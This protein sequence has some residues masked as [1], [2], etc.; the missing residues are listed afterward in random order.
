MAPKEKETF[1]IQVI[2]N[3]NATWQGT[4]QWVEKKKTVPYRSMLE[5][6][7]LIDSAVG[8][9]PGNDETTFTQQNRIPGAGKTKKQKRQN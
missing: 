3:Q 7:K 4:V 9:S 6:I 2:S 8:D 5:L 1:V